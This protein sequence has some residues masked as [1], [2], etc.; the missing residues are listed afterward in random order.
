MTGAYSFVC[1]YR[2]THALCARLNEIGDWDWDIGDSHWYG[3]YLRCKPFDGVRI[4]IVDFPKQKPGMAADEWEYEAD[5]ASSPPSPARKW[6]SRAATASEI[7]A[8]FRKVLSEIPARD[9]KE[10]EWFD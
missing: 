3:D 2:N 9:I 5:I 10:I 7:D 4:R 8:A 1:R 6:T